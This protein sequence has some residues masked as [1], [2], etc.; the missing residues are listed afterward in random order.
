MYIVAFLVCLY[1]KQVKKGLKSEKLYNITAKPG[2]ELE[3][4][5]FLPD[6]DVRT[7][8]GVV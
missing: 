7:Q 3:I 2:K 6:D 5:Y 1:N 8:P 4:Q